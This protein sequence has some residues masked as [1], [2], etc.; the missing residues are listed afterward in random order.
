MLSGKKAFEGESHASVIGAIMHTEPSEISASRPLTPPTL[1]RLVKTCLAKAPDDRWQSARDLARE[2][3]WIRA[4]PGAQPAFARR[5]REPLTWSLAIVLGVAIATT[6]IVYRGE[7]RPRQLPVRFSVSAPADALLRAPFSPQISPDGTLLAFM[8]VRNGEQ[9]LALRR[10][11]AVDSRVV[12]GTEGGSFPFWSPDS[13][14]IAFFADGQLKKVS[15]SGGTVQNIGKTGTALGGTWNRDDVILFTSGE[16]GILY[17]VSAAGGQ[18]T[19]LIS[20]E[21][22]KKLQGRPQFLPDGRRFLYFVDPDGVYVGSLDGAAPGRVPV[23]THIALYAPPGYLLFAQGR[24]VVAQR[25]SSDL[26]QPLDHPVTLAENVVTGPPAGSAAL[27]GGSAFSV[28]DTGVL[29]YAVPPTRRVEVTSFE[30]SG[31]PLGTIGPLPFEAAPSLEFSPNGTR[32]ATQSPA[33]P[34]PNAE[35]W[36]FNLA[37]RRATQLTFTP[38][39]DRHPVWSPDGQRVV[40][41]SRRADSP[42]LYQKSAG[43]QQPEELLLRSPGGDWDQY[44]PTDWSATGIVYENGRDAAN[45]QLWMLPVEGDRRP[46][47]V[48]SEAGNHHGA[49]VSPD[50]RWLAYQT[51]FQ[52]G[53]PDVVIQSL[54][55]PDVKVRVS[56]DGG[57][58]PRWRADG[59][60]LFYL[61]RNGRLMAVAIE[62]PRLG[63]LRLGK[64]QPLFQTGLRLL[65][66]GVPSINVSTDGLRFFIAKE[67]QETPPSIVVLVSWSSMLGR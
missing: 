56:T 54:T 35:I 46:Y 27:A 9:V 42:G 30:R 49:R 28:S 63:E 58:S 64:A 11:D 45:V 51:T 4:N 36:L 22:G 59:A 10:L 38:G 66:T 37:D 50:G 23:N 60:E 16:E 25:F 67:N 29:A 17:R 62:Q 13:R 33:G 57:S 47:P 41:S 39:A 48:V 43:G 44:W 2:L 20:L 53:P 21:A 8:S 52:R 5:K 7:S 3:R 15:A 61:S 32:L 65:P 6:M 12:T 55:T 40:F 14:A 18:P 24:A 1:D 26:T 19:P 31:R 34:D